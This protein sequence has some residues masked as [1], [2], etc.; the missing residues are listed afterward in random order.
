[1]KKIKFFLLTILTFIGCERSY[2]SKL[3]FKND[4]DK[5]I[6]VKFVEKKNDIN[7]FLSDHELASWDT[8]GHYL[9]P[10]S[11]ANFPAWGRW[12]NWIETLNDDKKVYFYVF[13]AEPFRKFR[14]GNLVKSRLKYKQLDFTKEQLV[15]INWEVV[16]KDSI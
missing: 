13:N 16:F 7:D 1:M 8:F 5:E 11:S 6:F 4:S 2:D 15:K 10:N 9:E 12:E 3:S 14:A